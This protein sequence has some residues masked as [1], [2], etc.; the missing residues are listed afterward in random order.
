MER[1]NRLVSAV[2]VSSGKTP[3]TTKDRSIAFQSQFPTLPSPHRPDS[4]HY[5]P[6][7]DIYEVSTFAP[8]PRQTRG[9]DVS[10]F[11]S[12]SSSS[13]LKLRESYPP[14]VTFDSHIGCALSRSSHLVSSQLAGRDRVVVSNKQGTRSFSLREYQRGGANDD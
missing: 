11:A 12:I 6:A 8:Y 3:P 10:S 4:R 1:S 7:G 9:P 2:L 5:L 13:S 14:F